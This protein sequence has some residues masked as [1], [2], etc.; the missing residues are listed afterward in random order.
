MSGED[1]KNVI[2]RCFKALKAG[3]LEQVDHLTTDDFTWWVAPTTISSGTYIKEKWL[4]LISGILGDLAGPMTLQLG[5]LTAEDD[6]VSVTMVG[7]IPFKSGK[8][9]NNH[10]HHLFW[11]RDGRISAVKE[12]L[13]TYHVGEIFGF[14]SATA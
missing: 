11:L 7:N 9:Y 1:N 13:D 5:D 8:V 10:Y 2:T 3:D 4:Q 6:R 12:Y 14:P